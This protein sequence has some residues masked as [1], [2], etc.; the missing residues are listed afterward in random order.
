MQKALCRS[1]R[2]ALGVTLLGALALTGIGCGSS[3][4]NSNPD[5]KDANTGS[6]GADAAGA[7]GKDGG[8]GSGGTTGAAGTDG[9]AGSGGTTGAAGTDGGAGNDGAAGTT[10]AAG[11]DGG[12]GTTGAAGA[13]AAADA[14]DA[15]A[16]SDGGV[17][18]AADAGDGGDASDAA[19]T[20]ACALGAK[21]CGGAGGIQTCVDGSE[22]C[23]VW[24]AEASCGAHLACSAG[25]G[26]ATCTCQASACQTAQVT[27]KICSGN[28]LLDCALDADGCYYATGA[29]VACGQRQSCTGVAGAASCTCN[30]DPSCA[31]GSDT[32][33]AGAGS[34]SHCALDADNCPY[35]ASTTACPTHQ[36]CTGPKGTAACSCDSPPADCAA[37]ANS[38][39]CA[40]ST[41]VSTCKA[42]SNNC[43]YAEAAVACGAHQTCGGSGGAASCSC[44]TDA[45]CGSTVGNLCVNNG[46]QSANCAKDAQNCVYNAGTTS[47]GAHQ[48]CNGGT[49]V[50]ECNA[51]TC[52]TTGPFCDGGNVSTCG[53]D[54]N[55]C[56]FVSA[57][58]STMCT[59]N[60]TCSGGAGSASC[61]CNPAPAICSHGAGTYCDGGGIT[62]C[63]A[64]PHGCVTVQ[65]TQVACGAHQTCTGAAGGAACTCNAAPA[66]CT[67]AGSFCSSSSTQSL[68]QVDAQSCVYSNAAN[69][70]AC[71]PHQTCEG[72]GLGGGCT[73]K[74]TCPAGAVGGTYCVD[75]GTAKQA[76]CANDGNSCHIQSNVIS[77]VGV[78]TCRGADGVGACQCPAMGT[79]EGTGCTTLGA[80]VCQGNTVLTCVSDG[81]SGCH[82]WSQPNDCTAISL[83][84]GTRSGVAS[85]Q[86]AEHSG[87]DYFA[88]PLNGADTSAIFPT[89]ISSP[90][91][92][93]FGTLGKALSQATAGSR[94]VATSTSVPQTFNA[95]TFPL[96]VPAGVTLTTSDSLPTPGDYVIGFNSSAPAGVMLGSSSTIEGFTILNENGNATAAA[97]VVTGAGA[98]VDTV[99]LE[100][101]NGTTLATGISVAGGGQGLLNAVTVQ[102]FTTGVAVAT[103]S[104]VAVALNNSTI[105]TNGT[106]VALTNGTLSAN[107]VTVNSGAG[108]GVSV[109]A[110][111]GAISTLNGT[112]L[113]V[114]NMTGV[115]IAQE[116]SGGTAAVTLTSA[117]VHHN[118][119]G[120]LLVNGG[121]GTLGAVQVHDNAGAGL[122]QS[123]GSV[124]LGSGGTTMVKS[125]TGNGVTL[126][127]GTLTV[128]AGTIAS[129]GGDGVA[130]T[131][132]ATLVS[133]AGAQYTSNVGNGINATSSTLQF[134]STASAPISA[135]NNGGDG[136]LISSGSLTANYL[137]LSANGTGS[138][139]KSGLEITGAAAINLGVASDAALSFTG[140]GLHG[141]NVN[142]TTA[143]SKIDMRKASLTN[144]GGDGM[145][146]DLNGGSGATA[147]TATLTSLTATGNTGHA[148]EV[149]RAPL[150]TST[151]LVVDGLTTKSNG[152]SGVYLHGAAT[153]GGSIVATVKNSKLQQNTGYGVLIDQSV[154]GTTQ[155]NLQSNDISGNTAGGVDFHAS[156]TLNGF[157]ANTIHN[158]GGDQ[159]LVEAAQN[160]VGTNPP[161]LLNSAGSCDPTSR[162]Q[163]WCYS[164]GHV[165]IR[166]TG[167]LASVT[168]DDMTWANA[169]PS[170]NTDYVTSG[171]GSSLTKASP[172]TAVTTCP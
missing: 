162:N 84:C 4:G 105:D 51:T 168:A 21:K 131:G 50:C 53:R 60:E 126:S 128:G 9:G 67:G 160:P 109:K 138:T 153:V 127:G 15:A 91:S 6:A 169:V 69:D 44:V 59:A 64:D 167:A 37:G 137:T 11:D 141:V 38:T 158:N 118:N 62:T 159:I 66:G 83:V 27:G 96:V 82:Y 129:N 24:S 20:N 143:G 76:S 1:S 119:G 36:S 29:A 54:A 87:G 151:A 88:D 48:A 16:G 134:N 68:C 157:A 135:S 49:G 112:S 56:L 154:T 156:S 146:V 8:A 42:D 125:N 136:I 149:A 18:D 79:T 116:S 63:V 94:V 170:V 111:A 32:L 74:D 80:T 77:C 92:C 121:T 102:G 41:S 14:A 165:G 23:T 123:A 144:N 78:Q 99:T 65:S 142:G 166:I 122:T 89:G 106:G 130:V 17:S 172:C 28:G 152:G 34:I 163:V 43:V 13:D 90:P 39:F 132:S 47:C 73:C 19:C 33:C 75:G 7:A 30:V 155:E 58:G 52:T 2:I 115:G 12:G 26:T 120:G 113:T 46:S 35:V 147:A 57:V 161:Y 139:K 86:C 71:G 81:P 104:G 31:T 133:N 95:E 114:R 25:S 3:G 150:G 10:G 45:T 101:T 72:T 22:G 55:N 110:A 5:A 85:C 140:N 100:G 97:L 164:S 98:T 124:T 40:T 171:V 108:D 148:I 107:T 145:Y 61:Q 117:D 93:R 70:T 103:T